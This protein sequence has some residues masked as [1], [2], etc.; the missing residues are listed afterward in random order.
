M[1]RLLAIDCDP[2]EI[3]LI[4]AT[5][6]GDRV[7]LEGIET[8]SLTRAADEVPF[9]SEEVGKQLQAALAKQK[10][11]GA[12]ILIGVDRNSVESFEFNVPPASD[13]ELPELVQT[14]VTME[15][16]NAVDEGVIDFIPT[17]G[18]ATEPRQITAAALSRAEISRITSICSV[19]GITPDRMLMRSYATAAL[20]LRQHSSRKGNSLLVN[21]IGDE[22]DLIVVDQTR[23]LFFRTVRLPGTLGNESAETRLLHEIRRTLLIAPQSATVA[24]SIEAVFIVGNSPDHDRIVRQFAEE[25]AIKTEILDP[26]ASFLTGSEWKAA[27][28][29]RLVPLLGMLVEETHGGHHSIDFL[30]PRRPPKPPNRKRQLAIALTAIA[31]VG[32]GLGYY[33]WDLFTTADAEVKQL[34][35]ELSDLEGLVKKTAEKKKIIDAIDDWNT[36]SVVWLDEIRD[37]SSR[38]PS[39]QDLVLQRLTM[40]PARG[41]K[42]SI[43]F[44][45]LAREPNVVTRM[46]ATLRD[47]RHEVQTPRV[48]ERVQDKSYT[49]NFETSVSLTPAKIEIEKPADKEASETA[50]K[51]SRKKS[52][53]KSSSK[54]A[55][56]PTKVDD[57]VSATI[58]DEAPPTK[59]VSQTRE[60]RD[61]DVQD[62]PEAKSASKE[63]G[64]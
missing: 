29:G 64:I 43:A 40:S 58:S 30:H 61:K 59:R 5:A 33:L 60:P 23:P 6:V 52:N 45:G 18:P 36:N 53:P 15:S 8:I 49:W 21:V 10:R 63:Q 51:S 34:A 28:T 35:D 54:L 4:L 62:K 14:Q 39:G 44:Q 41:G 32:G 47:S 3:C 31:L 46:E 55:T 56:P 26:L 2:R 48:D 25:S 1:Q 11:S 22:V 38:F 27:S 12:K 24:Q 17:P 37:L 9:T 19:A 13:G 20:F 57:T 16:P 50:Q 7:T 42:A